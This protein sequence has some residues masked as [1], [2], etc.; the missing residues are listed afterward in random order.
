MQAGRG[1]APPAPQD[2]AGATAVCLVIAYYEAG[3]GLTES[4]SSVRLEP[5]DSIVVVD[6]GSTRLP[7]RQFVPELPADVP[8]RLVEFPR[9]R[10]VAAA[11]RVGVAHAPSDAGYI[12][13][14]DC[15]D[16][17]AEDRFTV[18]RRHLDT[19]PECVIVGSSVTFHDLAGNLLYTHHQPETDAQIRRLMRVNCAFTQP[20]V[21]FRRSAYDAAGGYS[22]AYPYGEDYALFRAL[23]KHGGGYNVTRP[24]VRCTTM[25]GGI[26]QRHRRRQLLT[27]AAIIWEHWDWHP[28]SLYGLLRAIAQLATSRNFTSR[29]KQALTRLPGRS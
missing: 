4:L 2:G 1:D 28:G 5:G 10:G 16:T 8:L 27:R 26:S 6:D 22:E 19:H 24:L 17:C 20:A 29:V 11:A 9:N 23:L 12:A 18:Q 25:D 14:L 21:M 7:A 15:R 13:R 3:E